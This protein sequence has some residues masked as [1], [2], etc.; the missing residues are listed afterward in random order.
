MWLRLNFAGGMEDLL[1]RG[2][3][4][5]SSHL[6]ADQRKKR[7]RE[8]FTYTP[9]CWIVDARLNDKYNWERWIFSGP[10]ILKACFGTSQ[11]KVKWTVTYHVQ[12]QDPKWSAS[13]L[14]LALERDGSIGTGDEFCCGCIILGNF[15]G[16]FCVWLHR[17]K[18]SC[19]SY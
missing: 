19:K 9:R 4:G 8:L 14:L 12:V 13:T 18:G 5:R 1:W 15:F 7:K 10:I 2:I 3:Y 17:I 16:C 11:Q 6:T